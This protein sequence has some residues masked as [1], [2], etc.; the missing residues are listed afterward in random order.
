MTWFFAASGVLGGA[1]ADPIPGIAD[2]VQYYRAEDAVGTGASMT[3]DNAANPGAGVLYVIGTAPTP[4]TWRNG[5]AGLLF[6]GY[7]SDRLRT[8]GAVLSQ[9][10]IIVAFAWGEN[11]ATT[12]QI[13]FDGSNASQRNSMSYTGLSGQPTIYSGTNLGA[14][15]AAPAPGTPCIGHFMFSNSGNDTARIEPHGGTPIIWSGNAG[16]QS[17]SALTLG[18]RYTNSYGWGGE[19]GSI[20]VLTGNHAYDSPE[21]APAMAFLRSKYNI[22]HV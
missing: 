5:Q 13:L 4:V 14:G 10:T 16:A 20:A 18:N 6:D 9:A 12:G 11:N 21:A 15:V 2:V 3:V 17:F 19:I 7:G 22:F 1:L 8:D